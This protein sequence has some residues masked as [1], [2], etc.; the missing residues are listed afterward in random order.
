MADL[1]DEAIAGYV[2][3]ALDL[4]DEATRVQEDKREFFK[5]T[6][7]AHG[8]KFVTG[9]KLAIK[10]ALMD[11]D[12]RQEAEEIDAEAERILGIMRRGLHVARGA[13]TRGADEVT[14][15]NAS[16]PEGFD[17]E[18]GEEVTA[19]VPASAASNSQAERRPESTE[20][21]AGANAE[22]RA[23]ASSAPIQPVTAAQTVATPMASSPLAER[24][25]VESSATDEVS[26]FAG[27][28]ITD[29]GVCSAQPDQS[30]I[31][32]VPNQALVGANSLGSAADKSESGGVSPA[33]SAP[34]THNPETHFLSSRGLARLHGCQNPE[35]CGSSQPRTRLCFSCSVAHDG[36]T[37]Q[38][39]EEEYVVH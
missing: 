25:S 36:P 5:S 18:T 38:P 27:A 35:N 39:S 6:R 24:G 15:S 20:Q 10:V 9:L 1:S 23:P 16:V 22:E 31:T 34:R 14:T 8:K 37:H 12:K 2:A 3:H 7:E 30:E 21:S 13:R 28:T 32:P 19:P 33:L 4:E 29:R 17:P 11:A 26:A